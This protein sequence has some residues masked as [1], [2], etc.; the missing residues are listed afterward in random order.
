M[1]TFLLSLA[2]VLIAA[3]SVL[4]AVPYFVD[5]NQYRSQIEAQAAKFV[6]RPVEIDGNIALSLLPVPEL[7][8]DR[9]K[10]A[11]ARGGMAKPFL[12]ARSMKA[13]LNMGSLLHGEIEARQLNIVDPVLCLKIDAAG[14][15]NW[16][17]IGQSRQMPAIASDIALDS[18]TIAG[19]RI[20]VARP[21]R[22]PLR[23]DHLN[24][25]ASAASLDGPYKVQAHY[26]LD[27]RPQK[28][29]FSTTA[30]SNGS[31]SLTSSLQEPT[32]AMVFLLD[33]TV[34]GLRTTPR[35]HG[36]F[37][38]TITQPNHALTQKSEA[39]SK[40]GQPTVP[41][42]TETGEPAKPKPSAETAAIPAV[43]FLALKGTLTAT[44]L[45][46]ELD[47]FSLQ[48]HTHGRSQTLKGKLALDLGAVRRATATVHASWIDAD[49][50]LAAPAP[51]EKPVLEP[52]KAEVGKKA[53]TKAKLQMTPAV[54]LSRLA[55]LALHQAGQFDH[56][57]LTMTIDQA[58]LGGDL[59]SDIDLDL[60]ADHGALDIHKLTAVLPG[61]AKAS[62]QGVI[63]A[64]NGQPEFD[65]H[66]A[67]SG[68][69]LQTLTRWAVG[70]RALADQATSTG[71]FSLKAHAMLAPNEIRLA[72]VKGALSGTEF[73]GAM[74]YRGGAKPLLQLSLNSDRLD[75]RDVLGKQASL[76]AWLPQPSSVKKP[77]AKKKASR[78]EPAE[79]GPFD[80]LGHGEADV[81]LH[82]GALLLPRTPPGALDAD[83][84]YANDALSIQKLD[85]TSPGAVRLSGSG[86]ID[87]L[88]KAPSGQLDF[89][90]AGQKPQS[91]TVLA[92]LLGLPK[93]VANQ[94][95]LARFAPLDMH[96]AL[97]A[98]N[99]A[100][101]SLSSIKVTGT[102]RGAKI[103]LAANANGDL[104]KLADAKISLQGQ[105]ENA[106]SGEILGLLFPDLADDKLKG[107]AIA[108][109]KT[110]SSLTV[111]LHGVP[112]Q[113]L[114]GSAKL[115]GPLDLSF[116]GQGSFSGP[117]DK[118]LRQRSLSL[119]GELKAKTGDAALLV[120]LAGLEAPPSARGVPVALQGHL[121]K[122]GSAVT[123]DPVSLHV[124]ASN[125]RAKAH[126][127]LQP[128]SPKLSIAANANQV[129]LS[130]L[131]GILVAWERTPSTEE[132][133]GSITQGKA[134][135]WP[136][137]G[138]ALGPLGWASA[139]L[140]LEAGTLYLGHALPL[141]DARLT[142][143]TEAGGFNV[144]DLQGTLFGGRLSAS[145]TVSPRGEG[146]HLSLKAQLADADLAKATRSLIGKRLATGRFGLSG[147]LEGEGLSP[148]GLVADLAGKATL[149]LGSGR[150]T[151]LNADALMRMV[152]NAAKAN[153]NEVNEDR[154]TAL[155][156]I[157]RHGLVR[158][159]YP[160]HATTFDFNVANGTFRLKHGLLV[161]QFATTDVSG[162]LA[163]A[164]L[165]LDSDWNMR[166]NAQAASD[167]PPVDLGL[168]GPLERPSQIAPVIDTKELVSYFTVK[169]M[170][171]DV[172]RLEN[173]D[174]TG[175]GNP[176]LPASGQKNHQGARQ[177]SGK[178][179]SQGNSQNI[180]GS[181]ALA[182]T[183]ASKTQKGASSPQ[184]QAGE[185]QANGAAGASSTALAA[186][187]PPPNPPTHPIRRPT[188]RKKPP[189]PK[190]TGVWPFHLFGN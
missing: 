171:Q 128:K 162:Y 148:P 184:Q 89:A 121:A 127:L 94:D 113:G 189:P 123:L 117:S 59:V 50:L 2:I 144:K 141:H 106:Q 56:T 40:E 29:S 74:R 149:Q 154:V 33:G 190:H 17:D 35:Y 122:S 185:V 172:E 85:F 187:G 103:A 146:A 43:P 67:L 104:A 124:G 25:R 64:K 183:G 57:K 98:G 180:G 14:R 176:P 114:Q 156:K 181:P 20:E 39:G 52:Q 136:E 36:S 129:S 3:L 188:Y 81:A 71:S 142:A 18:V 134:A 80:L 159:S 58:S 96:V 70:D 49:A 170:Q 6:G 4:F 166:L 138:F 95:Y 53:E 54:A 82:V 182:G 78:A 173:L 115:E 48:L 60:D 65:G 152:A 130:S 168:A 109:A 76:D 19:G 145:A 7:R 24:G 137:R 55:A 72:G 111:A 167:L 61:D 37:S 150:I 108:A 84:T 131:L 126:L 15:G 30:A 178:A 100:G 27:G 1:N 63:E 132:I 119:K 107:P 90:V 77:G 21:G 93:D 44:P 169:R 92:E 135:A 160:F 16:R 143:Q 120:G 157:L 23:I 75:L 102:A 34:T 46:A 112:S 118:P 158:G 88:R 87:S 105:I 12:Q 45:H 32:N 163:L 116:T 41:I 177:G 151:D 10:I 139:D 73:G 155:A 62:A 42:A 28:V 91:L 31:F 47:R 68:S 5:F 147:H 97:K 83:F 179:N 86:E 38:A 133:L 11:D 9:I 69:K 161:N 26:R 22:P 99:Q 175:Q 8:F 66:F 153:A 110:T 140:S 79:N 174:V 101:A 51:E 164:S 13:S 165:W 186:D 125:V